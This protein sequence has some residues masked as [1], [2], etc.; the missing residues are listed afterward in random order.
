MV[1][2]L[3][4]TFA[5]LDPGAQT[6]SMSPK[7]EHRTRCVQSKQAAHTALLSSAGGCKRVAAR[8]SSTRSPSPTRQQVSR[9]PSPSPG[10]SR[11]PSQP[12]T[13]TKTDPSLLPTP[14][15]GFVSGIYP[16]LS[17]SI[18]RQMTYSLTRFGVYDT[19]KERFSVGLAPGETLPAWKMAVAASIAGGLGGIAGNPAD[20]VLVRM[21]GDGT[22]AAK[23]RLNYKHW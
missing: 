12:R 6:R 4:L 21:T 20:V 7:C 19:L 5:V 10:L 14:R 9:P 11:D 8:A 16:G 15:A 1:G 17:A 23:D 3:V 22:R 18:L 13:R 2:A